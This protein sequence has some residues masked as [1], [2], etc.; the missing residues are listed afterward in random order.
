MATKKAKTKKTFTVG[1]TLFLLWNAAIHDSLKG[2]GG[3]ISV[4]DL[5]SAVKML[6]IL[7]NDIDWIV[8]T[9]ETK[10]KPP[11]KKRLLQRTKKFPVQG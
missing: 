2:L 9:I 11:S 6:R 8:L 7:L 4:K 3:K 1:E 10:G 5:S